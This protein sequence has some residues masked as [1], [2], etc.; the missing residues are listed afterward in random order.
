MTDEVEK[1][2]I[3]YTRKM[4][5]AK[6]EITVLEAVP[7]AGVMETK[8]VSKEKAPK[9]PMTEKQKA[10]I[11]RLIQLNKEKREAKLLTKDA[12]DKAKAEAEAKAK[13][14]AEVKE[15][16]E[17]KAKGLRK[18][19]Y[20]IKPRKKR[21]SKQK[22]EEKKISQF[23]SNVSFE[24]DDYPSDTDES[25]EDTECPPSDTTDTKQIKRK[26]QKI[27]QLQNAII[28]TKQNPY[29]SLLKKYF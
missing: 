20:I 28:E 12:D 8:I 26:V 18:V 21:E 16:Q 23:K 10:N 27:K 1:Q 22:K 2:T 15:M 5:K 13:A 17:L 7:E 3:T 11:E 4:K 9:R 29:D 19:K 6:N 24:K 14:E 25:D